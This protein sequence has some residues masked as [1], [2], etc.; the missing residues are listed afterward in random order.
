MIINTCFVLITLIRFSE[1]FL[2][3]GGGGNCGCN[4]APPP[5]CPQISTC[6]IPVPCSNLAA[7]AAAY[8][9]SYASVAPAIPS[10]PASSF[11]TSYSAS[12]AQPKIPLL[13]APAP[14][15]LPVPP[16]YPFSSSSYRPSPSAPIPFPPPPALQP[17]QVLPAMLPA[18]YNQLPEA[19]YSQIM[20]TP[21]NY[22]PA[23]IPYEMIGITATIAPS[24]LPY[25]VHSGYADGPADKEHYEDMSY[26]TPASNYDDSSPALPPPVPND[27]ETEYESRPPYST[28]SASYS[29][30]TYDYKT[31]QVVQQNSDRATYENELDELSQLVDSQNSTW[32]VLPSS[33]RKITEIYPESMFEKRHAILKRM[34]SSKDDDT[35]PRTKNTCNSMK[36]A[37]VMARAIVDDVSVSKRMVQHATELAFDGAKFDVFCATG[38]FSYS[39]H[40]RKYCEVTSNDVTCFSF[41]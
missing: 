16:P 15:L 2:F 31:S 9:G 33:Q 21:P 29:P 24:T 36:L 7:P 8:T 5:R 26:S 28:S 37:N 12:Y 6:A 38:E 17:Q 20:I 35:V 14:V 22:F 25:K 30:Q 32:P 39:I 13:P 11:A 23:T 27:S 19:S 3:G 18:P 1:P 34:K 4:C 40:A 10:I 41:R